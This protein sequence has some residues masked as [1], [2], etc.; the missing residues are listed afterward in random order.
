MRLATIKELA[1]EFNETTLRVRELIRRRG[2]KHVDTLSEIDKRGGRHVSRLFDHEEMAREILSLNVRRVM[3]ADA[4]A[5]RLRERGT[6]GVGTIVSADLLE[7]MQKAAAARNLHVGGW[8][9]AA[10]IAMLLREGF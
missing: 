9:R 1:E 8:L 7:R 2:I 4:A 6:R 10:I 5:M 3:R